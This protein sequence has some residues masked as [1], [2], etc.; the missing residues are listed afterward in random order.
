[1]NYIINIKCFIVVVIPTGVSVAYTCTQIKV[2]VE[3]EQS[4][5]LWVPSPTLL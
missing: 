1:V 3:S 5:N 2:A 4:E